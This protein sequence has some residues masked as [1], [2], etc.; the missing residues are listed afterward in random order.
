MFDTVQ[1]VRAPSGFFTDSDIKPELFS[2][3]VESDSRRATVPPAS[4]T[5]RASERARYE[6]DQLVVECVRDSSIESES[7][8]DV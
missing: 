2:T 1:I 4:K 3:I 8:K 6:S 5:G 7:D